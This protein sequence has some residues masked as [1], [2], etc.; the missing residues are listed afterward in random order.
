MLFFLLPGILY[1]ILAGGDRRVSLFL[2]PEGEG[3]TVVLGGDSGPGRL[4][5]R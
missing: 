2:V 4:A 3:S 1:L 5:L